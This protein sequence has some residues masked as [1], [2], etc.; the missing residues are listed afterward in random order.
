MILEGKIALVTGASRGIGK[1]IAITLAKAGAKVVVNYA[2][3]EAAALEVVKEIQ[4]I[5]GQALAVQ[6]NVAVSADVEAMI[7]QTI[8]Q[9]G[10]ID[11]L[12][13]NAGITRDTLLM[14]MKDEDWD[15][16]LDTN[17]KGV[18]NCTRA[19]TKIMM[20]QRSG[21]IINISS[22][23]GLT[24]NAGQVN[25]AAAKAGIIGL[26]KSVAKELAARN[27]T[28]NAIAPGFIETDMTH[29]LNDDVKSKIVEAIPMK[30]MGKAEDVAN[31][32][33]FLASDA[34]NYIT[35]QTLV[36]DGGMVM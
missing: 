32:V 11:V 13:N 9:F 17:L 27:I 35:G 10:S 30:R 1:A 29:V 3:S 6:A 15:L 22:V 5:G 24:G 16:V 12:V 7:N 20:K 34:A 2:G 33:V 26:T 21:K 4:D 25:Y 18:Y 14:R 28:A 23:V 19:V 31:A 8:E 36:V